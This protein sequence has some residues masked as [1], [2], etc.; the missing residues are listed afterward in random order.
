[1]AFTMGG[2]SKW[3]KQFAVFGPN[4]PLKTDM[5]Q[6]ESTTAREGFM[7]EGCIATI[8]PQSARSCE[9]VIEALARELAC[10]TD[11]LSDAWALYIHD[12]H[13]PEET[14]YK[15]KFWL[16]QENASEFLENLRKDWPH[17]RLD[18]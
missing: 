2:A 14:R 13:A 15:C 17:L 4:Q 7:P 11:A 9:L 6:N 5:T 1:M 12:R 18:E 16:A 8:P 10:V 3:L